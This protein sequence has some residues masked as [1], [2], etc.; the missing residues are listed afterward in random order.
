L[1]EENG[2]QQ[3]H[4]ISRTSRNGGCNGIWHDQ[5][6]SKNGGAENETIDFKHQKSSFT[7]PLSPTLGPIEPSRIN[8]KINYTK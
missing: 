1:E 3:C 2:Y 6:P 8:E 7:N 5:T 4:H